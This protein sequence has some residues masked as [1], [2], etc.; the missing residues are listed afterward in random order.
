MS[1]TD[2][3]T[4]PTLDVIE[5]Q[6]ADMPQAACPVKH[7]FT[8]GLYVREIV[9]PAGTLVTS[10]VHKKRHP[11]VISKGKVRVISETEGAVIYTAPYTGITEPGT[12][13]LLHVMEETVWTTFHVT[14]LTDVEEIAAEILE[15]SPNKLIDGA[16]P[17]LNHWRG[18]AA[19]NL[20]QES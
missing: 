7:R 2:E 19:G 18:D 1:A 17:R 3:M 4:V 20:E 5:A 16:D 13:R 8:P 10:M 9:M 12:R 14:D 15:Q 6:M 11:F